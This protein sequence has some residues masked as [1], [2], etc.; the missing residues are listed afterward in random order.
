MLRKLVVGMYQAN[1]YILGCKDTGEGLVIDPGGEVFRIVKEI[2]ELGLKI[3]YIL[4]THGIAY[5]EKRC[6]NI[7]N[8]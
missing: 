8:D 6:R 3:R 5:R 2:S 4:I 7:P 1:C